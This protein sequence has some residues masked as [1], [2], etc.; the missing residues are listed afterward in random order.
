MH[1]V[2]EDGKAT[3][4]HM[5]MVAISHSCLCHWE[6]NFRAQYDLL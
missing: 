2:G 5:I 4:G 1:K 6:S 3:A